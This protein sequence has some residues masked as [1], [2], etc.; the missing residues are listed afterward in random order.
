[1][2]DN[3]NVEES[4]EVSGVKAMT[5]SANAVKLLAKISKNNMDNVRLAVQFREELEDQ[6]LIKLMA[7]YTEVEQN[8]PLQR[9]ILLTFKK[10]MSKDINKSVFSTIVSDFVLSGFEDE[11]ELK[12]GLHE[13]GLK[14]SEMDTLEL[15]RKKLMRKVKSERENLLHDMHLQETP[16]KRAPAKAPMTSDE[17]DQQIIRK[18]EEV[19]ERLNKKREHEGNNADEEEDELEDVGNSSTAINSKA[20]PSRKASGKSDKGASTLAN[21]LLEQYPAITDTG[22]FIY[23]KDHVLVAASEELNAQFYLMVNQV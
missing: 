2:A 1:M 13:M 18:A 8:T 17:R 6:N 23:V 19:M 20:K 21:L 7:T 3:M 15:A 9:L 5:L 4:S 22:V 14:S 10:Q 16:P 12:A 11:K